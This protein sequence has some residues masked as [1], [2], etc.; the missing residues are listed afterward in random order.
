[1]IRQRTRFT[2]PKDYASCYPSEGIAS[3]TRNRRAVYTLRASFDCLRLS[4]NSM[5]FEILHLTFVFLS[6]FA[7]VERAKITALACLGILFSR[8][9]TVFA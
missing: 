2:T 6:R 1:M 9:Q 8:I 4:I 5:A 7:T 3:E